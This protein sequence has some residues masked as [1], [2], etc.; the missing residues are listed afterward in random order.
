MNA[1]LIELDLKKGID[2]TIIEDENDCNK[3]KANNLRHVPLIE[4]E[5]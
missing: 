5:H 1:S 4:E 2:Y 3:F